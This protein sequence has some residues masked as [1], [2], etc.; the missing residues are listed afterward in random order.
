M[1]CCNFGINSSEGVL[2]K[3]ADKARSIG[4]G[5]DNV[6]Y[7]YCRVAGI[8]P[9]LNN[10]KASPYSFRSSATIKKLS[11]YKEVADEIEKI[12]KYNDGK[13]LNNYYK[14]AITAVHAALL[15]ID[16][17]NKGTVADHCKQLQCKQYRQEL[18]NLCIFD[19]ALIDINIMHAITKYPQAPL[20]FVIA[21]GSHIDQ[22]SS[23][24]E[25]MGYEL[26]FKTSSCSEGSGLKK[27][28]NSENTASSLDNYPK[29]I[30]LSIIEKF[31]R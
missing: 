23:M 31:I 30:D 7:R 17:N 24:L 8:G 26:L 4:I 20:I 21:G 18:E 29:P 19:S 2:A 25:H 12:K 11:L 15:K 5:V 14:R 9:L 13:L 3:L 27:V 22:V 28:L 10:I 6:E 1:V 16:F